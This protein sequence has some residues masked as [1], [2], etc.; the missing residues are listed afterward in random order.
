MP[1]WTPCLRLLTCLCSA[2]HFR[3]RS[4][5]LALTV[6]WSGSSRDRTDFA[7]CF[8]S[9]LQ[10]DYVN[11]ARNQVQPMCCSYHSFA[12]R[13]SASTNMGAYITQGSLKVGPCIFFHQA[14]SF[15]ESLA[16]WTSVAEHFHGMLTELWATV[17]W[18]TCGKE[19]WKILTFGEPCYTSWHDSKLISN[20]PDQR[21]CEQDL[22]WLSQRQEW[23]K[24]PGQIVW[25][26]P[27]TPKSNQFRISPAASPEI[28]YNI[29]QYEELFIAMVMLPVLNTSL[30]HYITFVWL[31]YP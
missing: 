15:E 7:S 19:S 17:V 6:A 20:L 25:F 16:Q 24:H 10:V 28:Q 31:Y 22:Q 11:N 13:S 18:N 4:A 29:T 23:R 26:D 9:A 1:P 8:L 2:P 30:I 27:F 5:A 12:K 14:S 3:M 21:H